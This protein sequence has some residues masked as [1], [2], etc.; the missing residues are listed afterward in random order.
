MKAAQLAAFDFSEIPNLE[1]A[2]RLDSA[3][4]LLAVVVGRADRGGGPGQ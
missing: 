2:R 3:G 4:S 1:T